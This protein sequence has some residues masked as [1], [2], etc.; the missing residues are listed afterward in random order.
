MDIPVNIDLANIEVNHFSIESFQNGIATLLLDV[1]NLSSISLDNL[2]LQLLLDDDAYGADS[3]L[4]ALLDTVI[5]IQ[6]ESAQSAQILLSDIELSLEEL[7]QLAVWFSSDVNCICLDEFQYVNRPIGISEKIQWTFCE[8]EE[9]MLSI[10]ESDNQILWQGELDFSCDTCFVTSAAI[11]EEI[12]NLTDYQ[13]NAIVYSDFD[14]FIEYQG[15]ITVKN[16]PE[17]LNDDLQI[18]QGD[19]IGLFATLADSYSWQGEGISDPA[20]DNIFVSPINSGYYYL[21]AEDEEGCTAF[22]SVYVEVL[23]AVSLPELSDQSVCVG[24]SIEIE[25]PVVSGLIYTWYSSSLDI[26]DPADEKQCFQTS[27]GIYELIIQSSNGL[28]S[29][30]DTVVLEFF[31]GVDIDVTLDT[32]HSCGNELINILLD[33]N[34]EYSWFPFQENMCEN[35]TCSEINWN[36]Q[37]SQNLQAIATDADGCID[38]IF[39]SLIVEPDTNVFTIDTVLCVGEA[40]DWNNGTYNEAGL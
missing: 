29:E 1:S 35:Q 18:C 23:P 12:T 34:Y 33:D 36:L 26:N 7:C 27:Q 24:Q 30:I 3:Y 6:I 16:K 31:D 5:N 2:A 21:M 25:L 19:T 4:S 39:I 20:V 8:G 15:T 37:S 9:I 13:V 28:C 32:I 17:I 22:D 40:F 10:E 14:C 38:T 11:D